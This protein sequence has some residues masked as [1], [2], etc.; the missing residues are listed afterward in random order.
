MLEKPAN[1]P[2]AA[3]VPE[4]ETAAPGSRSTARIGAGRPVG[5]YFGHTPTADDADSRYRARAFLHMANV[6]TGHP[7][8]YRDRFADL[9][10]QRLQAAGAGEYR[11]PGPHDQG[12]MASQAEI[13]Q[14]LHIAQRVAERGNLSIVAEFNVALRPPN[15]SHRLVSGLRGL[16]GMETEAPPDDPVYGP[17]QDPAR[18]RTCWW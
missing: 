16:L 6:A 14:S 17:M 12:M 1:S 9:Q 18:D 2:G 5:N 11:S 8:L 3:P 15:L 10:T 7:S 13:L 4:I